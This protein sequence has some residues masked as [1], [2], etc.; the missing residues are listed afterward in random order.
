M[1]NSAR[2]WELIDGLFGVIEE[3]KSPYGCTGFECVSF[4][5]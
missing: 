1:K 2:H 4:E 3:I 5:A